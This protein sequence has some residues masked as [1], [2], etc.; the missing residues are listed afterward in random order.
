[1]VIT[2]IVALTALILV[3]ARPRFNNG[4]CRICQNTGELLCT[5]GE[6]DH[7]VCSCKQK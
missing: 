1:M 6:H 2:I 4:V 3:M 5:T 7:D